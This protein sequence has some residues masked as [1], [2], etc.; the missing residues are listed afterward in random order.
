MKPL[1]YLI[2]W[3]SWAGLP[4]IG[5][6]AVEP[7]IYTLTW[8][9]P[10]SHTF[11]I[12][13][14][15]S[16]EAGKETR[17]CLPAW[18]PGRY[19]L[20]QYAAALSDFQPTTLEGKT[21]TWF[22]AD[23]NTWVV[24]HG[25]DKSK[26][27]KIK[28]KFYANLLDAGSSC[29]TEDLI[30][31]N[32][33]N[34]FLYVP[35]QKQL[36][37]TLKLPG[38]KLLPTQKIAT[39]LK[40][41]PDSISF[42]ARDYDDLADSPTIISQKIHTLSTQILN[43]S[44][45]LHFIGKYLGDTV[46][47]KQFLIPAF[48]ALI[49]EQAAVFG[50][51]PFQEY[52]FIYL[53]L[54]GQ[55]RHA[56]E[57]SYSSC[58]TLP[59]EVTQ[60]S[61]SL[62]YGLM[63]ITSHEF[64]HVWNVK[65][66]RPEALW[67]Y[68]YQQ[69]AYTGLHWFTEGVTTYMEELT[70]YRAGLRTEKEFLRHLSETITTLENQ[71]ANHHISCTQSS[72]DSWLSTSRIYNPHLRTS[73]YGLGE[74]AGLALDL[75]LRQASNY[76]FSIED[77]FRLLYQEYYLKDKGVPEDGIRKASYKLVGES[78]NTFFDRYIDGTQNIPWDSLLSPMG[79]KI[80][81]SLDTAATWEKLGISVQP[82]VGGEMLRVKV[83]PGSEAARAGLSDE[84]VIFKVNGL[85]LKEWK[86]AQLRNLKV[87]DTLALQFLRNREVLEKRLIFEGNDPPLHFQ[88]VLDTQASVGCI[89]NKYLWLQS[90][91]NGK[92]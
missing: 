19:I 85:R 10:A 3:A 28:Y 74:R 55:Q 59:S 77:L 1:I 4:L 88:I 76:K 31:F 58:Y 90:K 66:I 18:R 75:F 50:S 91:G 45:Y 83:T 12:E 24:R 5:F 46:I 64:W 42:L 65:R 39:A 57:H 11:E 2:F 41:L 7:P 44:F 92:K 22:K 25:T 71:Y 52:H 81:S 78:A 72:F 68:N 6:T 26:K 21:L 86:D 20:Q 63:G 87:G 17:F 49:Q 47:E 38:K 35:S 70:L 54:P 23:I 61:N 73:Y 79:M 67:P 9:N 34:L 40:P 33:S 16:P 32:G 29:L 60:S 69:E 53:L 56:V 62:K 36:S 27:I 51:L 15:V 37:C 80:I 89:E 14:K 13:L 8:P 84:D 48:Q 82:E 30:Y 43:T